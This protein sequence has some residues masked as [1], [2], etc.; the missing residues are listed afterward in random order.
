MSCQQDPDLRAAGVVWDWFRLADTSF[1]CYMLTHAHMDHMRGLKTKKW[2]NCGVTPRIYCTHVTKRLTM[3]TLPQLCEDNFVTLEYNTRTRLL[4]TV[5]VWALPSY[6]CDGSCMFLFEI[7]GEGPTLR[8]LYT[9]DFRFCGALRANSLLT[10]W[11]IH[12]MYYDNTFD[13]ITQPYPSY[14]ETVQALSRAI[15]TRETATINSSI[16]GLEPLLRDVAQ[17]HNVVFG[18]S[19]G[20]AGTYRAQ[21][22]QYLLGE[23]LDTTQPPVLP[24]VLG[25]RRK[26]EAQGWIVPTCTFFLCSA[27]F[28]REK[29]QSRQITYVQLCTHSNQP[30]NNALKA[31][32]SAQVVKSCS[33]DVQMLKCQ[34]VP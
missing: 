9:G 13:Q 10:E 2:Q 34:K 22:L 14:E 33:A 7:A 31:L 4:N 5:D 29:T 16:L 15:T 32:V 6:H 23:Y 11:P 12:R 3:M 26:D 1:T 30:E 21:Q 27:S 18:L 28:K 8:I 19:P 25:H 20:L 17:K 24:Y